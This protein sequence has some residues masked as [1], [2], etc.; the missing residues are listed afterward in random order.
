MPFFLFNVWLKQTNYSNY[1]SQYTQF[2][3][4]SSRFY[5][6]FFCFYLRYYLQN[7]CCYMIF[8]L[9]G[10]FS[11]QKMNFSINDYFSKF[12]QNVI[13]CAVFVF[14]IAIFAVGIQL[15]V[16]VLFPFIHFK[17]VY[18]RERLSEVRFFCFSSQIQIFGN[19]YACST[20]WHI[21]FIIFSLQLSSSPFFS[22]RALLF[23]TL[24]SE[25]YSFWT[26][27]SNQK[28]LSF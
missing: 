2:L 1:L 13:F 18:C 4:L 28:Q 14:V 12:D 11:A 17:N 6:A 16:K 20:V 23:I 21:F 8:L 3:P 15:E 24:V 9:Q 5:L 26:K 22:F 25:C 10:V 27:I 19:C 7:F